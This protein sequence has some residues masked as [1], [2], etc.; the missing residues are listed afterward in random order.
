MKRNEHLGNKQSLVR[1]GGWSALWRDNRGNSY[2][3]TAAALV[4]LLGMVGGGVDIGRAY[5]A[6]S[7]LQ[8]ACDAGVLAGRRAMT[9]TNYNTTAQAEANKMFAFNYPSD[10]YGSTGVTFTSAA[11]GTSDVAGTASAVLPTTVMKVFNK[12]QFDLSVNCTARLEIANT[13]IMMVLDVTGSMATTNAG[14][15]VTRIEALRTAAIDFFDTMTTAQ[16]GDGR[17]RFGVV[18]Y[19]SAANVGSILAAANPD[20]LSD[21]VTLPSR[22][23]IYRITWG[24]PETEDDDDYTF[25]GTTFSSWSNISTI[26]AAN[27][28]ECESTEPPSD[29]TPTASGTPNTNQTGQYVDSDGNRVTTLEVNQL[30]R[31]FTYRYNWRSSSSTCRQ[32]RATAS[33]YRYNTRTITETPVQTFDNRYT[34]QDRVF[35]VS[36]VTTG[37]PLV[38]DTGTGGAQVSEPWTGCVMERRTV[39]YAASDNTPPAALD[40]DVDLVPTGDDDTR[41]KPLIPGVSFPRASVPWNSPVSNGAVSVDASNVWGTNWANYVAHAGNGWGVCPA[42]AMNLTTQTSA[43]RAGFVNY[44]NSL[45]PLGGTYHDAGMVWGVRLMSPDGLFAD[46]NATAPNG[47]PIGRH[48]IFMTDGEMS[49]TRG[50]LS[51]QGYEHLMKRVGGNSDAELTSRHNNRFLQLCEAARAKGMTVWVVGFGVA[52]NDELNACASPGR[53]FAASNA[54]QLNQQFQAIARQISRLRISQ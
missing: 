38:T 29:T 44:I 17:L 32:Q 28:E 40:M 6:E 3:L 23:P 31:Y 43:D 54:T 9:G 15:S 42:A 18:P 19:S 26:T 16:T 30:F 47:R 4:P 51:H 13:D 8:Q 21:N 41:W 37:T 35:D 12:S 10:S 49:A 2:F 5:M 14:D 25:G 46:Q 33:Y 48:I 53:A 1:A 52:L 45:Q 34:Y 22:T 27:E 7:R 24:N 39:P 50:N 36:Q 11:Q 20:W